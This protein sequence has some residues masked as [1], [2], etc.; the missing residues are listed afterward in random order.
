MSDKLLRRTEYLAAE[1]TAREKE[2]ADRFR[3]MVADVEASAAAATNVGLTKHGRKS[4]EAQRTPSCVCGA[5]GEHDDKHDAHYCPVSGT[6]LEESCADRMCVY[7]FN[8][9]SCKILETP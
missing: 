6:W 3:A 4:S 2:Q 5:I 7:C 9:P 8:R 1:Q